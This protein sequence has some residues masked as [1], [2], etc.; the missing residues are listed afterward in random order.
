VFVPYI[1][2]LTEVDALK[3]AYGVTWRGI[4]RPGDRELG[5]AGSELIALDL[6]TNEVLAVRRGFK[7]SGGI[8]NSYTGIW[9]L[10][11]QTCPKLSERPDHLFIKEV[12]KP[13]AFEG[14]V[15]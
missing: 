8:Q 14:K 7:R 15:K 1:V 4:N 6:R 3:S 5:I 12:L 10:T 2:A 11:G 13:L 9:W